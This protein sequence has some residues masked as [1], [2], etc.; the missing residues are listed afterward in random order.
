MKEKVVFLCFFLHNLGNTL[1][2]QFECIS[3]KSNQPQGYHQERTV[4][5]VSDT[6]QLSTLKGN[7]IIRGW[8]YISDLRIVGSVVLPSQE[9]VIYSFTCEILKEELR[10]VGFG[11][12]V[13]M[14]IYIFCLFENI[15]FSI[16]EFFPPMTYL[17]QSNY[18][19]IV[20]SQ[21]MF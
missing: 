19:I 11:F 8:L 14:Q 9:L 15:W 18:E 6:N 2:R 16:C 17:Y 1:I 21:L 3:K 5:A 13:R 7:I 12:C 20:E 10:N 4:Y